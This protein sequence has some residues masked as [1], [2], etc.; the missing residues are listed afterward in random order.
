M[1]EP[2]SVTDNESAVEAII[3]YRFRDRGLLRRALAHKSVG[4]EHNERL[5]FLGDAVLGA[6]VSEQLFAAT[7]ADEGVLSR[8]R[9]ALV[10]WHILGDAMEKNGLG[11]YVRVAP[12]IGAAGKRILADAAEAL[13]GAAHRDG[14]VAAATRVVKLLIGRQLDHA[15]SA[16]RAV[17]AVDPK[18]KL[19]ISLQK[20]HLP[21]PV[22]RVI[23]HTV[24][25]H[26]H[27]FRVACVITDRLPFEGA[28]PTLRDAE[29]AAARQALNHCG[30]N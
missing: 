16:P 20:R 2:A 22:Y 18:L 21:L 24:L 6:I 12:S 4:R 5:E 13:I 10:N 15:C 19:Q 26:E 7:G 11:T 17:G 25:G 14:G 30:R 28:G 27:R 29:R 9:S 8:A 23:Q 3:G 1:Y